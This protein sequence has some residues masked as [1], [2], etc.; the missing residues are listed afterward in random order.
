M[1]VLYVRD[2]PPTDL[3]M[4]IVRACQNT[5][6]VPVFVLAKPSIGEVRRPD[7]IAAD[8]WCIVERDG[9]SFTDTCARLQADALVLDFLLC[10]T[11]AG[12]ETGLH[13]LVAYNGQDRSRVPW[14]WTTAD[15]ALLSR[16]AAAG[17]PVK[18]VT[19]PSNIAEWLSDLERWKERHSHWNTDATWE[20]LRGMISRE[21]GLAELA[22]ITHRILELFVAIRGDLHYTLRKDTPE[23]LLS[24]LNAERKKECDEPQERPRVFEILAGHPKF[25][26]ATAPREGG[27]RASK[28]R[29]DARYV[30]DLPVD[31]DQILLG[32]FKTAAGLIVGGYPVRKRA[33]DKLQEPTTTEAMIQW[34]EYLVY[35][36]VEE[37]PAARFLAWLDWLVVE[38]NSERAS[39]IDWAAQLKEL[40]D[41]IQEWFPEQVR[42]QDTNGFAA[43]LR[44]LEEVLRAIR[45]V[46]TP[47]ESGA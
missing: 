13:V 27:Q 47:S 7:G 29:V 12:E 45:E 19:T 34:L 38:A 30:A 15:P 16:Q 25:E 35:P 28:D 32:R 11:T 36:D 18:M 44:K 5:E 4:E 24:V 2:D 41:N 8:Q 3:P 46:V 10:R 14:A 6:W 9:A 42:G 40:R 26:E 37:N 39:S 21:P 43:W 17:L 1:R 20:K 33:V 22:W 31:E 23:F